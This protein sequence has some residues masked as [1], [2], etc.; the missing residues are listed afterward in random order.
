MIATAAVIVSMCSSSEPSSTSTAKTIE[1]SPRGPNQPVKATLGSR[2]PAPTQTHP[3][4]NHS[5]DGETQHGI[6]DDAP[7]GLVESRAQRDSAEHDERHRRQ[8]QPGRVR[9]A[10]YLAAVASTE[11][12]EDKTADERGDEAATAERNGDAVREDGGGERDYLQPVFGHEPAWH[13]DA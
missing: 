5:D 9:E 8:R 2:H 6:E 7:V 11:P 4:G 10:G 12:A 1:A 3:D 13:D